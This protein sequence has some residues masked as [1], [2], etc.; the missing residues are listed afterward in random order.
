MIKKRY[1]KRAYI[2]E[3]YCDKCGAPLKSTGVA[4]LTDP[5]KYPYVC[6]KAN[7]CG[8]HDTIIFY[9]YNKPGSIQYEFEEEVDICT[10]LLP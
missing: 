10:K 1:I 4:Y 5:L 9:E 3:A 7:E 6:S 8:C 2:T